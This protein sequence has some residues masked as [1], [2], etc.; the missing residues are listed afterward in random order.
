MEIP[1]L[2][3]LSVIISLIAGGFTIYQIFKKN[4]TEISEEILI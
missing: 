3:D 2:K 4:K 1:K